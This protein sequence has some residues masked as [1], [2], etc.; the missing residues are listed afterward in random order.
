MWFATKCDI[1]DSMV[2]EDSKVVIY[3]IDGHELLAV[4][5]LIILNEEGSNRNLFVCFYLL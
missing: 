3:W 4:F 2:V 1:L 5:V